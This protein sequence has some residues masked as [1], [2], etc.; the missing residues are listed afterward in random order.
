MSFIIG[1]A[2]MTFNDGTVYEYTVEDEDEEEWN[3]L[4]RGE[5]EYAVYEQL[6]SFAKYSSHA[7]PLP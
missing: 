6:S 3:E 2:V 5:Q 7:L 4:D 1:K